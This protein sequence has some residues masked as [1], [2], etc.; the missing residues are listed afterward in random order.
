MSFAV[1]DS[2]IK[3]DEVGFVE[4]GVS[5]VVGALCFVE[6]GTSDFEDSS[7]VVASAS[8]VELD[9]VPVA[10]YFSVT[11]GSVESFVEVGIHEDIVSSSVLVGT[12][13]V[14]SVLVSSTSVVETVPSPSVLGSTFVE[15]V[16]S[17][18]F[19]PSS[20]VDV[21]TSSVLLVFVTSPSVV[22]DTGI[23]VLILP[24]VSVRLPSDAFVVGIG[25]ST[26]PVVSVS[27]EVGKSTV[28][29]PSNSNGTVVSTIVPF[30]VIL[31]VINSVFFL[32][33][34]MKSGVVARVPSKEVR[35]VVGVSGG[36]RMSESGLVL[37]VIELEVGAVGFV[38]VGSGS[39]V[40][41]ENWVFVRVE[42]GVVEV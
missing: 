42:E 3:E 18:V 14:D 1:E 32:V 20:P 5:V 12:S 22:P 17:L 31:I 33:V 4:L 9:F 2:F 41:V 10:V 29:V 30:F 37:V 27:V 15:L 38:E 35:V 26:V 40:V 36:S 21:G 13:V 39:M 11:V 16:F 28:S 34:G 24:S 6:G 19:V 23:S 8:V 25:K 7:A